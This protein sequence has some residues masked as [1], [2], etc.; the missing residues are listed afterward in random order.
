M[1]SSVRINSIQGLAK[2]AEERAARPDVYC[3][4]IPSTTRLSHYVNQSSCFHL[5]AFKTFAVCVSD[6]PF[7]PLRG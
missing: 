6:M 2:F 4:S 1:F 7:A 5:F 3:V